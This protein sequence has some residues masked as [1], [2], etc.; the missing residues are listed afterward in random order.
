MILL[1]SWPAILKFWGLVLLM[2]CHV[3][4]PERWWS[5][6]ILHLVLKLILRL[7][8][9]LVLVE[10]RLTIMRLGLILRLRLKHVLVLVELRLTR[11]LNRLVGFYQY[12]PKMFPFC[13]SLPV[14][15][16]EYNRIFFQLLSRSL[17]L[18]MFAVVKIYHIFIFEIFQAI[19]TNR[20][21][22]GPKFE[23][24]KIQETIMAPN[25]NRI[26]FTFL[27]RQS[28]SITIIVQT[29][30]VTKRTRNF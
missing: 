5:G 1:L 11:C 26:V 24:W 2:L 22:I 27:F 17:Q 29:V 13:I 8:H 6:L 9:V 16:I 12:L 28:P 19:S 10:L 4:V 23:L 15:W 18:V 21:A 14:L 20:F 3:L 25:H 30:I 7:K